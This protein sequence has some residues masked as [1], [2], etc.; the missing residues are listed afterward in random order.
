[1]DAQLSKAILAGSLLPT[2]KLVGLA[3][4]DHINSKAKKANI[5]YAEPPAHSQMPGI[6]SHA[7]LAGRA[8]TKSQLSFLVIT[9]GHPCPIRAVTHVRYRNVTR[10][11]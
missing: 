5:Q 10:G 4:A 6:S 7:I 9:I 2:E 1:M 3:L 11:N 8:F